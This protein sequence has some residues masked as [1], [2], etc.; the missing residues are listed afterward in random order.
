MHWREE[1][2]VYRTIADNVFMVGGP[3]LSDPRD[4]LCYLV[5]G[6]KAR[7]LIDCGAGPSAEAILESA[8][9]AGGQ[10]PTHLFITHAHIDHAG[11]AAELR[12]LC[13]CRIIIHHEEAETLSAGDSQRSAAAWYG[14]DLEPAQPDVVLDGDHA[15]DLGD[16]RLMNLIHTPGHTPGSMSAWVQ[17][18]DRKILFGQDI[19]G[20]FN[21]SFGSDIGQWRGSMQKL[22]NLEADILAE[23]HYGIFKPAD[24]VA[25]FITGQIDSH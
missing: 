15:L 6:P 1:D 18:G 23:G 21:P 13:G 25:A 10:P 11:G 7:L 19:H 12:R 14:L 4:C 17:N 2:N 9:S 16:G 24:E 5:T 20:P 22:L 8:R 3:D